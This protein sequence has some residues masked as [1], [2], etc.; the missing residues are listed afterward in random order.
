MNNKFLLATLL[1]VLAILISAVIV[2]RDTHRF[3]VHHETFETDKFLPHEEITIVQIS[4]LHGK[5]FAPQNDPLVEAILEHHAD[6]VVLTGDIIDSKTRD[7]A[8]VFD[9]IER[10]TAGYDKVYYVSGN[11]EWGNR[12]R[13]QFF[14]GLR[15]RGV[16]ILDNDSCEVSI[17]G[18]VIQLVGV[19]DVSAKRENVEEAFRGVDLTRYTIL[20]SHS[21]QIVLQYEQLPAD[22]ILSGHTHGGQVRLPFI[23]ALVAPHQGFFPKLDKGTFQLADEQYLYIDSGLGTSMLPIRFLNQSQFSVLRISGYKER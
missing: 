20:L 13:D 5:V 4:D 7:F 16:K 19:A 2:Y 23:G 21:P 15:E 22:L 9:F 18:T 1:L 12:Y 10:I 11:H 6:L 14:A 8:D 17:R 3:K